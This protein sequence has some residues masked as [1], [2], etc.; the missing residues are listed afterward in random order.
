LVLFCISKNVLEYVFKE[1][2]REREREKKLIFLITCLRQEFNF[3][4]YLYFNYDEQRTFAILKLPLR[5]RNE[6]IYFFKYYTRILKK[7]TI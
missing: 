6:N 5:K 4:I 2:E 1:R 3:A 7:K